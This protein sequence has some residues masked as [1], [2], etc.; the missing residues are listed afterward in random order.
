MIKE[1]KFKVRVES[2]CYY[3]FVPFL[4]TTTGKAARKDKVTQ[5]A[6][7]VFIFGHALLVAF[8]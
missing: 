4:H 5:V 1:N 7:M 6:G 3:I 8:Y 2:K